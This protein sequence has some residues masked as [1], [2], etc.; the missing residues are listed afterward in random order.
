[1]NAPF[2]ITGPYS[3]PQIR[4]QLICTL[5]SRKLFI[6]TLTEL[7]AMAALASTGLSIS[8]VKGYKAP[9]ATGMPTTL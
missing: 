7:N 8:P 9:A 2:R 6:T 4:F 5:R 3:F 1:M